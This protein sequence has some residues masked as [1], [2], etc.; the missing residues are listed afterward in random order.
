MEVGSLLK[1]MRAA[2]FGVLSTVEQVFRN[3]VK[4]EQGREFSSARP[5]RP[6]SVHPN[7]MSCGRASWDSQALGPASRLPLPATLGAGPGARLRAAHRRAC[8]IRISGCA[9]PPLRPLLPRLCG[10]A[11]SPG[12]PRA[13]GAG[14]RRALP[15]A[16]P[17]R[18][19]GLQ[20]L[21]PQRGRSPRL[22]L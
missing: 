14:L 21:H 12:A 4:P 20:R 6:P 17:L 3:A 7:P 22:L 13:D 8:K 10:P 2:G 5:R 19:P 11:A 18:P 9:S 15:A 1:M 16:T